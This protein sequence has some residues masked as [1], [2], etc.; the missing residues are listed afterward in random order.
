MRNTG[1]AI[2]FYHQMQSTICEHRDDGKA[3]GVFNSYEIIKVSPDGW[4]LNSIQPTH[5]SMGEL[6]PAPPTRLN[7]LFVP[8]FGSAIF[9]GEER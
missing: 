9:T 7:V 3:G 5:T 6:L 4:A 1:S 2:Y 8:K